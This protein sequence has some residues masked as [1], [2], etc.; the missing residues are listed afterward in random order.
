MEKRFASPFPIRIRGFSFAA[1]ASRKSTF[2]AGQPV[3]AKSM[4]IAWTRKCR[5]PFAAGVTPKMNADNDI[6]EWNTFEITMKGDRLWVKLN[7]KQVIEN[8]QLPGIPSRGPVAL[9]HHGGKDK[10]G[11]WRSPPALVQFRNIAIKEMN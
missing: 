11:N 6:G 10:E 7:G 8:A 3:R 5:L 4:V 9:Q 2:G 1:R